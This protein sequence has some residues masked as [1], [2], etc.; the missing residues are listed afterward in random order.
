ME[1]LEFVI[2]A[3]SPG[4]LSSFVK[5]V[6]EKIKSKTGKQCQ[7]RISLFLTPCQFSSGREIEY[8]KSLGVDQIISAEEYRKWILGIHFNKKFSFKYKGIVLYLGGDLLHAVLVAKKLG[9]KVYAYLH[10]QKGTWKSVFQR[11][12]VVDE[13]A[14]KKLLHSGLTE[15]NVK[16]AGDLMLNS[17]KTLP[18]AESIKIWKLDTNKPIVAFLPGS[19]EWE[20]NYMLPFYEIVGLELKKIIPGIQLILIV[21]PFTPLDQIE[22]RMQSNLFDMMAPLSSITAAD[23]AVTIPGTNNAQIAAAGIPLLMLLPINNVRDIPL[24]GILHYFTQIPILGP[25]LKRIAAEIIC[26]KTKFFSLPNMKAQK[27]IVP[28]LKGRIT[29]EEVVE[30]ILELLN[31]PNQLK[32]IESDLKKVMGE[33]NAAEIIVGD[34]LD[35]N[36]P[37]PV[38]LS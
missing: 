9:Y 34:I 21:S 38:N 22:L 5:P 36:L 24:V 25:I 17:V 27:L 35:E 29:P 30:K 18:K 8:A 15:D 1:N 10:G 26:K 6:V 32:T 33:S 23:L 4:E 11:F 13:K 19:R 12:Y 31:N 20:I 28:E 14:Q 16:I 7:A 3:N 2:V 37:A